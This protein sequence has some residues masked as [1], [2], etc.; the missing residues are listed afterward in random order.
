MLAQ[1]AGVPKSIHF[2]SIEIIIHKNIFLK[3]YSN[4][5]II[6]TFKNKD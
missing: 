1:E 4:Y 2:N 5:F 3:Y 6:E